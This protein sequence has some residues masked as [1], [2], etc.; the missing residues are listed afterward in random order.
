M[1]KKIHVVVETHTV[2][3]DV[4]Y[5]PFCASPN[6]EWMGDAFEDE[7]DEITP[8]HCHECDSWFGVKTK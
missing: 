8:W 3:E 1:S 7:G 4:Q 5:C 2:D 6:I